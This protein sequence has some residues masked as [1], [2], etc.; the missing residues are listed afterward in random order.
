MWI[1]IIIETKVLTLHIL[2]MDHSLKLGSNIWVWRRKKRR[3]WRLAVSLS[4]RL[5]RWGHVTAWTPGF[6]TGRVLCQK[7][8]P[9]AWLKGPCSGHLT[10]SQIRGTQLAPHAWLAHDPAG[11]DPCVG[12]V[13]SCDPLTIWREGDSH[14]L[15][16]RQHQ[17]P[18]GTLNQS[19][20]LCLD[21]YY[22]YY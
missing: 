5:S 16:V 7:S 19:C 15:H 2:Y 8:G 4:G 10:G 3:Q 11:R 21:C 13:Q 1:W 9:G 17:P 22:D 18:P 14:L 6:L 20:K 12:H